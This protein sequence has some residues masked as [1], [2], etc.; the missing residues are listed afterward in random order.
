M[1]IF[2]IDLLTLFAARGIAQTVAKL[3]LSTATHSDLIS[4]EVT[5][6]ED[7]LVGSQMTD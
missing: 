2:P 6:Y 7:Y 4:I 1:A 5:R 3:T